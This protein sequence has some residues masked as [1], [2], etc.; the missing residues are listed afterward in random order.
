MTRR[1]FG[2]IGAAIT[3]GA[4][5]LVIGC[6]RRT[7]ALAT[8]ASPAPV[9]R[10]EEAPRPPEGSAGPPEQGPW[11]SVDFPEAQR[12]EANAPP[13]GRAMIR[14]ARPGPRGAAALVA[15]HGHTESER[16]LDVGARAWKDDYHLDAAYS[17]LS[18]PA[19]TA[20]DG[21][22]FL[23][24]EQL[25]ALN[26]ELAERPFLG[27]TL[28]CPFTPDIV[29]PKSDLAVAYGGFVADRLA[30]EI[31]ALDPSSTPRLGIDGISM[32]GR[33]ALMVGFSRPDVFRSVGCLQ[34]FL[35]PEE[36]EM[37]AELV[38]RATRAQAIQ[39]VT[40][41]SD[42]RLQGVRA[43][44]R[45]L[46]ARGLEHVVV[47]SGGGQ[48][49]LEPDIPEPDEDAEPWPEPNPEPLDP[50]AP[51]TPEPLT[52]LIDPV[53]PP[54]GL[55]SEFGVLGTPSSVPP[56]CPTERSWAPPI[57]GRESGP[58]VSRWS[59]PHPQIAATTSVAAA[60][61]TLDRDMVTSSAGCPAPF[62]RAL[63]GALGC[64]GT[65]RRGDGASSTSSA[66]ARL[67]LVRPRPT[68]RP[69]GLEGAIVRERA[70]RTHGSAPR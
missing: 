23:D 21:G 61:T 52:A 4:A 26:R 45:A 56:L 24:D 70:H 59:L 25:G 5:G 69:R 20:A 14:A 68:P 2:A 62:D 47:V 57:D 65:L 31:R 7:R 18:A 54:I 63:R 30:E 15:L 37:F 1:A 51:V 46:D 10:E 33:I 11:R 55:D 48:A 12:A 28:A 27:L 38:A 66:R 6:G 8:S 50:V 41:E 40:A 42:P 49:L 36:A 19:L 16:G 32:G 22:G 44:S 34:P 35:K 39:L 43:L 58:R 17:R 53:V 67:T 3:A 60:Q 13:F 9:A 64:R 29:D